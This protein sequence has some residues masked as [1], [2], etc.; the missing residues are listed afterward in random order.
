VWAAAKRTI[1][2]AKRIFERISNIALW[3]LNRLVMSAKRANRKTI[4]WAVRK[5]NRPLFL[6]AILWL[7]TLTAGG[8]VWA[9]ISMHVKPDDPWGPIG[10]LILLA[11][12]KVGRC[13]SIS[14]VKPSGS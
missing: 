9:V 12:N 7:P 14:W 3:P 2:A 13:L 5:R 8:F 4:R 6:F 10:G 1:E 11:I